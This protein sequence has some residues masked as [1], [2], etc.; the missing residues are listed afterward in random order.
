MDVPTQDWPVA[1]FPRYRYPLEENKEY[2]DKQDRDCL[3]EIG[4]LIDHWNEVKKKPVAGIVVE[5]IQSEGGDNFGSAYFF[6]SLQ[7]LAKEVNFILQ[8]QNFI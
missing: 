3:Q 2:N 6:Q 1:N 8:T 7:K 4:Q 5:P